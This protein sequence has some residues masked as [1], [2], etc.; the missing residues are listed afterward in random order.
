MTK[1]YLFVRRYLAVVMVL[2]AASAFAQQSVSG[3][4]TSSDDGSGIPGVNVLEK[5]TT[6]GTVSDAD[7][8]YTISVG[9]NATLS[10]SFV[11]YATQDVSVGSQTNLNVSLKPDVTALSEVVVIGY[12]TAK[13]KDATGSVVAIGTEN[14]NKGVITTPDQ[15]FNG[16]TAGLVITPSSGEPGA[17]ST[18]N[19]RGTASIRG[20]QEPLYV[21]D[22]VPVDNGTGTSATQSGVE[23]TSTPKNPLLF[24]NPNDIESVNILKDA[25]SAAIYGSRGANGVIL[26]TT[27]SG[28]GSGKKG[29]FTFNAYTSVATAAKKYDLLNAKDF[30]AGVK[31]ANIDAGTSAADAALAV[32]GPPVNNGSSTDWQDQIFRTAISNGYNLGWGMSSGG[33]T[34]RLSGSYDNQQGIIKN[35]GLERLT[36][37][38]NFGQKFLNEKLK[39]DVSITASNVKNTYAPNTNNAGYQGSLIGAAISYNPTSPVYNPDGS[40]FDLGDGNR[41]AVQMLTYFD[42]TDNI[43]RYL[44]N[45]SASYEIS[46]GLVFK[47]TFGFNSSASLRKSFADP[48]LGANAFG[49]T[50]NVFGVNYN[51]QISG[52][53]R[54]VYQHLDNS[55]KL[56]EQT[57]T[58]D[59][60]FGKGVLNAIAG[61][62][63]QDFESNS[64]ADV[65]WGLKT[66]VSKPGDNFVKDIGNFVNK[67][68]AYLP[69]YSKFTLQSYFGRVNYAI[70]DK[71]FLTGTVRV[72][73]S[74]KFGANNKYGTFPAFAAKWKINKESFA[75]NSIGK[76]FSEFGLRAN[77]GQIGSQDGLGAYDAVDW[78]EKWT[79]RGTTTPQTNFLRQGNKDLKWE[80]ATTTGLGLDWA[81][82]SNRL[83]GTIDYYYTKR[84]DL[85]Y[86]GPIPGGF[87]ASTYA[88]QNLPGSVINTGLEFSLKYDAVVSSKFN[89]DIAYNMTFFNNKITDFT[90]PPVN[91]GGVSGQ[92]LSG[93]YAQTITN[94]QSLFTWK[95]P[96][97]DGFD[98]N[99][100]AKYADGGKDQLLGSALPTF[101]AGLTNN[102]SYGNW[103]LSLFFTTTRGFYVYNNTANALFLK[104][105][106]KTAHNV[107]TDIAGSNESPI[108]PGSVST[109][110]LEKGDFIRL[111]NATLS[112]NFKVS[113][114][115]VKSLS[116]NIAGQN[117]LLVTDYTGL[118]PEVNVDKNLNGIPSR[119]FDYVGYPK[120]RT[121]TLGLNIGF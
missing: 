7:G 21:I 80:T 116:A 60:T 82:A 65:A 14:F 36:G 5:G 52:N 110:F 1:L 87:S 6:N 56:T 74:S 86:F 83:S 92:G 96:V 107:P 95:M 12:G 100:F 28:K 46:K 17:A 85:L 43:G 33:T 103:N 81:I 106:L 115:I 78:S 35:S 29:S 63:F 112:Y 11:G 89:W 54:A 51:N 114:K 120:P 70:N 42:D 68:V 48:R 73:G 38:V 53:G 59:K 24:L 91:T 104:G 121:F 93:A 50:T 39:L 2:G 119:G 108:N 94:G 37:R 61:Y 49:G 34:L 111:S 88:Y 99:G 118:D 72:D 77:W 26:I 31:K 71:Y 113:G 22:G 62:S 75:A 4:V 101:T 117:L 9:A 102:F 90:Q 27:K 23:G 3:K 18:I 84:V 25:S 47:S 98:G 57:L 32:A 45:F 13:V 19:I 55:S 15:L 64:F 66:P 79:P 8:N 67:D 41:N 10:F 76:V 40:F 105:S 58:Y 97:F 20:N 109:R 16:R 69:S 30:L 44:G